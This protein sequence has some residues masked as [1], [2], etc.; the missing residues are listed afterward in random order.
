VQP[1]RL[2]TRQL[3]EPADRPSAY[4]QQPRR[5]SNAAP[6]VNVLQHRQAFFF[7]QMAVEQRRSLPLAESRAARSAVQEPDGLAFA[8]VATDGKVLCSALAEISAA[9]VLAAKAG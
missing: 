7:R 1:P 6:F 3:R 2:I 8:E 4:S 9:R 5:L